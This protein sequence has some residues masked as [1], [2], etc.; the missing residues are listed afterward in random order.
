MVLTGKGRL[1]PDIWPETP[2]QAESMESMMRTIWGMEANCR[3]KASGTPD[4]PL[5]LTGKEAR[6]VRLLLFCDWY[7]QGC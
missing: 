1:A 3:Q 4:S 5:S 7:Q 2:G 6:H